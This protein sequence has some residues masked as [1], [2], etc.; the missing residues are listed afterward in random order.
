MYYDVLHTLVPNIIYPKTGITSEIFRTTTG[1]ING[2]DNSY[3]RN[4][5][6]E[7]IVLMTITLF[8]SGIVASQINETDNMSGKII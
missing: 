3:S 5:T 6:S 2:D 4:S 7:T 8:T 1:Q